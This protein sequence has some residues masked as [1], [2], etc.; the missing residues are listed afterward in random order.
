M[1]VYTIGFTK[2]SAREF[3][4]A[5]RRA[6]I[7]RLIDVRLNNA[8]QL[9]GFSKR[10]DLAFFLAEIGAIDYRHMPEL[11]PTAEIL[12]AYQKKEIDWE[13]YERRYAALLAERDVAG[14][15]DRELFD[16]PTVLLCSEAKPDHCHRRLLA[17]HLRA[18]WGGVSI[19]HL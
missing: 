10:D 13:E 14:S 12:R 4:E 15:L 16:R 19:T 9:A 1:E 18:T 7:R 6:G 3:F 2:K 5:L 11:A 8:S 17:E